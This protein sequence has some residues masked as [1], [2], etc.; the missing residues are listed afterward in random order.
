[1][2]AKTLFLILSALAVLS[3]AFTAIQTFEPRMVTIAEPRT[4]T[5]T[6][7]KNRKRSGSSRQTDSDPIPGSE[8][9]VDNPLEWLIDDEEISRED[10]EPFHILLLNQ[11]YAKPRITIQ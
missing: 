6:E 2:I 8:G 7:K 9:G 4:V 1:M 10:D 3:S 11:T 5:E